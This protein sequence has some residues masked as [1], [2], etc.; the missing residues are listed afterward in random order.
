DIVAYD[1]AG[2]KNRV[3]KSIK[4]DTKSDKPI[5]YINSPA[6]PDQRFSDFIE[7]AGVA[8]DDDGI[9]YVDYRINDGL[10]KNL[11]N[12]QLKTE[13]ENGWVTLELE[14]GKP[15]WS[16][17][18]DRNFLSSGRHK[19]EVRAYD[20]SGVKSDSKFI[21]FQLDKEN[22]EIK[23]FSPPNGSFLQG[24]RLITGRA[25]DPNDIE[26]VE[27]S[28]S[29]GWSFVSAEG[30]ENW[31]YYLNSSAIPDGTLKFL[32][33]ARDNA[34]SESFSFAVYNID[35]K[36]PEIDILLPKDGF[37]VNNKYKI[38]G[39][40]KDNIGI[41]KVMIKVTTGQDN[42]LKN[43]DEEGFVVVEGKE[44][45]EYQID[46]KDW[47]PY[48]VYHLVAKVYD[49]AGNKT[50]KSLD[51]VVNPLSDIPV[52]ELDQ[53]QANQHLT[54]DVI[55]FF[56]TARDD[57]G[58]EAVFIKIDDEDQVKVEGTEVWRYVLPTAKLKSGPHKVIVVAQEKGQDG[59]PGKFSGPIS[60][61]F[62]LDESG[63]VIN[64]LSHLNGA[65]MEHRPWL[66]GKAYYF[67]KD[68][69][70]KIKKDIQI[71]KYNELKKKFRRTPE[72][73][74]N[75]ENIEV[76]KYEITPILQKYLAENTI[77]SI[78]LTLDN[79]N[80]YEQNLGFTSDWMVRVQTQYLTDGE[81]T[82]QLKAQTL[83]GK[84][85]ISY[86]KILIDR[87]LPKVII[88]KPFENSRHND[89]LLVMGSADDNS[90]VTEVKVL[91][92]QFDK[93][94]GKVPKFIQGLYLWAQGLG[95]P[96]VSGGFGLSFF[97]DVVRLEGLFGWVPTIS[98]MRDMGVDIYDK[99]LFGPQWGWKF[100]KYE[101][102]FY[103]FVTGGKLLAKVI[104]IPFEFFWGEDARNFSWSLAIGAGFY[105]FSGFGGGT[106]EAANYDPLKKGKVLAGF[107][108]QFDLFKV[109]RF[110]PL[111]KFAIYFENAF[112]FIASEVQSDLTPQFG[113]GIRNS[114][115]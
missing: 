94:V 68:L 55:E 80:T 79:G 28:T 61:V 105:W 76:K 71:K 23:L 6:V 33:K 69:E 115:F 24:E 113:F 15:N 7:L 87:N 90:K 111:R 88:D 58:I 26:R 103:G 91:L 5:V 43:I 50:E 46:V 47:A 95:G 4:F 92:K 104:D 52:V 39:R 18:I 60:R 32:I 40:A 107:M 30:K 67:E 36:A 8:L 65:P 19:L 99:N 56:G 17:K 102:R 29:N 38:V 72:K 2:N 106:G 64:V 9:E 82:L 51:F 93:N 101:P 14:K 59:K 85:S 53:P 44:A 112:Y 83:N 3:T 100:E 81:H 66:S 31:K 57:D 70:L 54:G 84:E 86:F 110:G 49:L 74:P 16:V 108:Y 1:S 48:K 109:E 11:E 98:N 25:S 20:I 114:F 77:K 63:A 75:V 96:T 13:D 21:T 27:I 35:N 73:I 34:G 37:L 42:I 89:K 62:Y 41:E 97:D 12:G 22:P 10:T 78:H 45:W